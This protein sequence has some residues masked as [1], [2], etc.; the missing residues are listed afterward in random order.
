MGAIIRLP[1]VIQKTGLSRS[2]IYASIAE[3]KFPAQIKLTKRSS[4]WL[5]S[6]IDQWISDRVAD[7]DREC[8]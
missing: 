1:Q 5:E 6:E 8:A 2:S 7:R 3:G 4:G